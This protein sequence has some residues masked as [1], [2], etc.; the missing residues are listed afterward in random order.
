MLKLEV[1]S[2]RVTLVDETPHRM[3][4]RNEGN[5][6]WYLWAFCTRVSIYFEIHWHNT[7]AGTVSIEFLKESRAAC[8]DYYSP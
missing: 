8:L 6:S 2:S 1:L 5:Y 3:L 4:E 7:R